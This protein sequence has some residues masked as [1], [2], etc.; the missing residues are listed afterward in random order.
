MPIPRT[1][2]AVRPSSS[3]SFW[4]L[5]GKCLREWNGGITRMCAGTSKLFCRATKPRTDVDR[6]VSLSAGRTPRR[7]GSRCWTLSKVSPGLMTVRK[8]LSLA[9][10][11]GAHASRT[12]KR[13]V[14]FPVL[15]RVKVAE[16]GNPKR[17]L[18]PG[19]RNAWIDLVEGAKKKSPTPART[20]NANPATRNSHDPPKAMGIVSRTVSTRKRHV[21]AIS[22]VPP[23]STQS[24]RVPGQSQYRPFEPQGATGRGDG[25]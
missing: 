4:R 15:T 14:R 8:R 22:G 17:I 3:R 24:S 19:E 16:V 11:V 23:R 13:A 25:T 1:M 12:C 21:N 18:S 5:E 20:R 9:P 10:A 6:K 2:S 7:T